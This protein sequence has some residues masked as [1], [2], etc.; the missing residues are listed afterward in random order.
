MAKIRKQVTK[1]GKMLQVDY[2]PTHEKSGRKIGDMPKSQKSKAKM[3]EENRSK[4]I[5]KFILL[6]NANF[7][8]NNYYAT[9]DYQPEFAPLIYE[10]AIK[11]A[12]NYFNR[13]RRLMKK[14]GLNPKNL[15]YAY[16]C[17]EAIY[18][19]G[20]HKG[21]SNYHFHMFIKAD[22]LTAKELKE[23]WPFG[24]KGNI[25]NY[26]PYSF[27]PEAAAKYMVKSKAGRKMYK[28][29]KNLDK[30]YVDEVKD[31]QISDKKLRELGEQRIDDRE[32]WEKKYPS[33]NFVRC[34]P[35]YNE[36]NGHWYITVVMYKKSTSH[37]YYEKMRQKR[38]A[39]VNKS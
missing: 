3:D 15:K 2:F 25:M 6:V 5:R 23:L 18:K 26:D 1:A 22:G 13:V 10:R 20:I 29:S 30:P 27:G 35:F 11:D 7:D 16:S 4:A 38:N 9:F 17:Q 37:S 8:E 36:Y 14:K 39:C 19:R 31:G 24:T 21:M 12:N 33:Y 34:R 28:C 32:Y